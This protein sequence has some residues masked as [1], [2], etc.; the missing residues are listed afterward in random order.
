MLLSVVF[1]IYIPQMLNAGNIIGT[2]KNTFS[3][4]LKFTFGREKIGVLFILYPIINNIANIKL[5]EI[6]SGTVA[7]GVS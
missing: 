7:N 3:D 4:V 1:I 6:K 2:V 5:N